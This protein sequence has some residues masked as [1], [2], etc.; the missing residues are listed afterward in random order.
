MSFGPNHIDRRPPRKLLMLLCGSK[1]KY[2][3]VRDL[4]AFDF[5]IKEVKKICGYRGGGILQEKVMADLDY[6]HQTVV[7]EHLKAC[8]EVAV[9]RTINWQRH[10]QK[11]RTTLLFL[12]RL[13]ICLDEPVATIILQLLLALFGMKDKAPTVSNIEESP[14]VKAV[15]TLLNQNLGNW[16]SLTVNQPLICGGSSFLQHRKV[17]Q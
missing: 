10:C 2:R 7:V 5:H 1:E 16:C 8:L 14:V 6:D 12:V 17:S 15:V 4:H 11:E 3:Q 13:A 9:A